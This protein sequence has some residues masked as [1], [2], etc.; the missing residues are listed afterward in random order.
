MQN[1]ANKYTV[2]VDGR[3]LRERLSSKTKAGQRDIVRLK[4]LADIKLELTTADRHREILE[5][6]YGKR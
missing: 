1:R 6:F 3:P 4:K 5:A 2:F